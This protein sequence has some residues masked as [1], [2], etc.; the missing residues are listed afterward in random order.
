VLVYCVCTLTTVE[1]IGVATDA[2]A[3]L[4]G[5]TVLDPP[6]APWRAWGPGALLLPQSC[7]TD[8]MFV[9]GLRRGDR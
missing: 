4:P 3:R 5:W 8:G 2:V 9:L 1:T 7:G 6:A